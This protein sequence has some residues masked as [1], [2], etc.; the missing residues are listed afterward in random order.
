MRDT[1][2]LIRRAFQPAGAAGALHLGEVSLS[3]TASGGDSGSV[4]GTALVEP[5]PGAWSFDPAAQTAF[6]VAANLAGS[7]SAQGSKDEWGL[8]GFWGPA[9]ALVLDCRNNDTETGPEWEASHAYQIGDIV[10]PGDGYAYVCSVAGE[11][12][13][14]EPTWPTDYGWF[15]WDN[16]VL[17]D[18]VSGVVLSPQLAYADYVFPPSWGVGVGGGHELYS[19]AVP[20]NR[21]E[22]RLDW[23][24]SGYDPDAT[25]AGNATLSVDLYLLTYDTP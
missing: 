8:P 13:V 25:M 19:L 23:T 20:V 1:P 2:I 7:V 3:A 18:C 16:E 14:A 12:D 21:L 4:D 9:F 22:P 11:S 24:L 15:V 10:R 17:W 5:S 6:L